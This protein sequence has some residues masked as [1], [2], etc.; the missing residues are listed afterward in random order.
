MSDHAATLVAAAAALALITAAGLAWLPL[1]AAAVLLALAMAA[2][3]HGRRGRRGLQADIAALLA[4]QQG[5]G[6]ALVPVWAQHIESSRSQMEVAVSALAERF[7]GIVAQ[8]RA[9]GGEPPSGGA[10]NGRPGADVD[11]SGSRDALG[12]V[13]QS[14]RASQQGQAAM[15]AQVGALSG[16]I[17]ELQAMADDVARI[18]QQTNLLALNA[19]IEAARAGE[20]GRSF[21]VVAQE[22]RALSNRS[23][24]S[25]RHIRQ[26]VDA[27]GSA[28]RAA[29]AAAE[30]SLAAEQASTEASGAAIG[31]VLDRLRGSAEALA[32]RS[33]ELQASRALMQHEIAEALVHLQFQDRISQVMSHVTENMARLPPLLGQGPERW[34]SEGRLVPLDAAA[35]LAELERSYAMAEERS[36]HRGETVAAAPSA[37]DEITF[38]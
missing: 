6:D 5:L 3:A 17:G 13:A 16:F 34:T 21:A 38:F 28:I 15:L 23:A 37:A 24:E 8:L 29:C 12:R 27:V 32:A 9:Q 35:L 33:Q 4:G 22:V 20:H 25:G 7:S 36:A 19:A 2:D 30:Q 11:F 18:A 1:G 31:D 26:K 14:L 10:G